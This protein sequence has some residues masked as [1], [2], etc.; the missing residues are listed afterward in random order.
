MNDILPWHR[1]LLTAAVPTTAT[2]VIGDTGIGGP[3]LALQLAAHTIGGPPPPAPA[4]DPDI[5]IIT[6][7]NRVIKIDTLRQLIRFLTFSPVHR[8][9]RAGVILQA[10]KMTLSAANLLLK[11]LEEPQ[12]NKILILSTRST[13][14]LPVTIISRCHL[15]RAPLPDEKAINQ[16]RPHSDPDPARHAYHRFSPLAAH[17]YPPDWHRQLATIYAQGRCLDTDAALTLFHDKEIPPGGWLEGLQRWISDG[18][19]VGH[20]LPPL[21]FPGHHPHLKA[22]NPPPRTDRW[23]NYYQHLLKRRALLDHP[24]A[25]DLYTLEIL[26]DYRHLCAH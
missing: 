16:W 2:L 20:G 9:R 22:L 12:P 23:H 24:L 18:I 5:Q 17:Q 15:I 19:R 6:P 14:Q 26:H 13:R 25:K 8:P 10:E 7:D 21:H 4:E 1:A 11:T 3:Q